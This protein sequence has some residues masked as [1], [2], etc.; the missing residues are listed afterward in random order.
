MHLMKDTKEGYKAFTN[1][2]DFCNIVREKG[3]PA[4]NKGPS[5]K[6]INN[7]KSPRFKKS[8]VMSFKRRSC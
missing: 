5:I 6:K 4:C 1:F 2:F 3:L 7:C 8:L